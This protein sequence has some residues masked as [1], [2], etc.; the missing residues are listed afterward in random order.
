MR[1]NFNNNLSFQAGYVT[2]CKTSLSPIIKHDVV[3][4]FNAKNKPVQVDSTLANSVN[5]F[6]LAGGQGTR[7]TPYIKTVEPI[8][9]EQNKTTL[10]F[11]IDNK[12]D[13]RVIDFPMYLGK[14]FLTRDGYRTIEHNTPNGNFSDILKF[15]IDNPKEVKDT[16][17]C[18]GDN[19]YPLSNDEL[20]NIIKTAQSDG[21]KVMIFASKQMPE[22]AANKFGIL[23]FNSPNPYRNDTLYLDRFDDMADVRTFYEQSN[24]YLTLDGFCLS[25]PGMFF[26]KKDVMNWLI[27]KVKANPKIIQKVHPTELTP[28]PEAQYD[29][30]AAL[31]LIKERMPSVN[32]LI[33]PVNCWQDVGTPD[34]YFNFLS[35]INAE[36]L[37]NFP[38]SERVRI[39]NAINKK[40]QIK[41]KK[42][43]L[44]NEN[45]G[46]YNLVAQYPMNGKRIGIYADKQINFGS[47][48]VKTDCPKRKKLTQKQLDF[49]DKFEEMPESKK[50]KYKIATGLT[51]DIYYIKPFKFVIKSIKNIPNKQLQKKLDASLKNEGQNLKNLFGSKTKN[52]QQYIGL[53]TTE[54]GKT[55]LL[56]QYSDG[57]KIRKASQLS[58]DV[59]DNILQSLFMLDKN[60][61]ANFDWNPNN[62]LIKGNKT[63]LIDFQW[64]K[65][66]QNFSSKV[67]NIVSPS[68]ENVSNITAFETSTLA[69]LV[70]KTKNMGLLEKYLKIKAKYCQKEAC[71]IAQKNLTN[72]DSVQEKI[73]FEIIKSKVFNKCSLPVLNAEMLR[74]EFLY[75]NLRYNFS[76]APAIDKPKDHS[77]AG[78]YTIKA[79][80]AAQ[81]LSNI[82]IPKHISITEKLYLEKMQKMGEYY[83]K[84]F[85]LND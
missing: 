70:L 67:E 18:C 54:K 75:N 39:L 16:L 53:A 33:K 63:T 25:Y 27:D 47:K 42:L 49:L 59:L 84:Y 61:I 83:L 31:K 12:T 58:Y 71:F 19:I 43:I 14:D 51:A 17:V 62:I 55:F 48:V 15:Y 2:T 34:R 77:K 50:N 72:I 69:P 32:V 76:L 24:S 13:L 26:I 6:V 82:N 56:T 11:P 79:I 30:I 10:P 8:L 20:K 65:K 68:F 78:F 38:L 46:K 9:G 80:K 60:R 7:M 1:I 40:A 36:S 28:C 35:S 66:L 64:A 85:A 44:S 21:T 52:V 29:Y 22:Y 57:K 45:S 23:K 74:L 4:T 37:Q 3:D 41:K 81:K 73:D 5:Y